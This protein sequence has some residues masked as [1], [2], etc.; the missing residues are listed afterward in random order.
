MVGL[1]EISTLGLASSKKALEVS[2]FG[3]VLIKLSG[4]VG[5]SGVEMSNLVTKGSVGLFKL[6]ASSLAVMKRDLEIVAFNSTGIQLSIKI[7]N[8]GV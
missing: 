5:N 6:G 7:S 3:S 4:E 2:A 1:F 8:S